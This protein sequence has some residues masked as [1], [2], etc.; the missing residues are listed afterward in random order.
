MFGLNVGKLIYTI[1]SYA[2]RK[3]GRREN[4]TQENTTPPPPTSKKRS[5]KVIALAAIC[6]ILAASLVAV[7][8]LYVTK[9]SSNAQLTQKDALITSLEQQIANLNTSGTSN[10]QAATYEAAISSLTSQLDNANSE[11]ADANSQ[12]ADLQS[13]LSMNAT[14]NLVDSQW[15]NQ[16]LPHTADVI[17]NNMLPDAGFI[18]VKVN[19]NSTTTYAET[20]F[21]YL[22]TNFDFN[23]TIGTS[24][25]AML[26]VMPTYVEVQIGNLET[27][28]I[29]NTTVSVDYYY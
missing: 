8:V 13:T 22:G 14:S 3:S 21:R 2:L 18:V 25:T 7:S 5:M 10:A 16:Q 15:F 23:Q 28:S 4:M 19:S 6:I 27:T 24:G 1:D 9:S 12:I 17:F 29:T 20:S 26:L 11:L